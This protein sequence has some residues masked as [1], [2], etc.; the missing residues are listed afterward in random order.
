MLDDVLGAGLRERDHAIGA[1]RDGRHER[2]PEEDGRGLA[3]VGGDDPGDVGERDD[4]D[5]AGAQRRGQGDAV[6]QV[7]ASSGEHA[8]QRELADRLQCRDGRAADA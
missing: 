7:D 8:E 1:A 3:G 6:Q 5:G 4:V 2:A